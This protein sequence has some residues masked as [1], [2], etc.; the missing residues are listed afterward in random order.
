MYS[1]FHF[2]KS[3]VDEKSSFKLYS[4]LEDF[5]FDDNLISCRNSGIFPDLIIKTNPNP[6]QFTGG[7]MVELKRSEERR[8]G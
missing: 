1:I 4:K 5:P 2:F 7:E 6:T 8:G 3:L